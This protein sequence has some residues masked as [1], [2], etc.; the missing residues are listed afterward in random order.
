MKRYLQFYNIVT[1]VVTACVLGSVCRLEIWYGSLVGILVFFF[2][3]VFIKYMEEEKEAYFHF[4]QASLYMEQ[5]E[6]SFKKNR[7][8]YQSL[9][10]T[11]SLFPK[12]RMKDTLQSAIE[13]IEKEEADADTSEKALHIIEKEYG[14]EQMELMHS[15]FLRAQEEGGKVAQAV[16]ILEK[17]RNTW[18]D[19]VEQCRYEKKNMLFS[20]LLSLV[21]LFVVSEAMI[22]LLPPEMSIMEY[23]YE[24]AAVVAEF[25]V[26]L[27]IARAVLK[28]NAS[29]WLTK[30]KERKE[31]TIEKDYRFIEEYN[32]RKEICRSIKWALIPFVL[33]ILI[34]F[35]NKSITLCS[36]GTAITI[37]LLNQHKLDYF[38]K[39]KRLKRE[40]ERDFPRW[41]FHVI[42]LLET[43]SV[44]G[45]IYNSMEQA[46]ASLVYP[47]N[48]MWKQIQENP[49][50]SEPYFSF[51]E[52]LEVP[53][54]QE[55]MKL[56]YSISSGTGGN[57]DEQMLSIIE[58]NNDMTLRSEKLKNDNKVAGM[59][60]YL[61]L[62]V[63]PTG[64]KLMADLAMVLLALY[65]G[66]GSAL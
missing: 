17:R 26:L 64:M 40:V 13:E 32:P 30:V 27:L 63:L 60:G 10:E 7:R 54:V 50:D 53:K 39:K 4:T 19:A 44:Q 15:F 21:L 9:K 57:I 49:T 16:G 25:A 42:L 8:I 51:L 56:L 45:A 18:M 55:A 28:K 43:E 66:L 29:V 41:M 20:V 1:A 34:F 6:S 65:R 12:G 61:F 24:R 5:M 3:P 59:M 2:L 31:E 36:I 58:K 35:L 46:P 37:L 47:L 62:P 22:F 14:C 23:S 48:R 11:L 38:L 33:T 52:N